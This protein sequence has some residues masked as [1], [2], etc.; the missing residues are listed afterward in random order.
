MASAHSRSSAGQGANDLHEALHVFIHDLRAPISVALGYLRLV[1]EDRLADEAARARA[2]EQTVE[3]LTRL[4]RLCDHASEFL[5]LAGGG[6]TPVGRSALSPLID[7]LRAGLAARGIEAEVEG[8][9]DDRAVIDTARP[10]DLADRLLVVVDWSMRQRC[11]GSAH[12]QT[13]EGWLRLRTGTPETRASLLS[14]EPAPIDW[15]RGGLGLL[16]AAACLDIKR[17]G[18]RVWT[19]GDAA[20]AVCV[21]LP[22]GQERA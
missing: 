17:H 22:V 16:L 5:S 13:V 21:T 20:P 12:I 4:S 18:G 3:S 11:G 8:L 9:V 14:G 1:R 15:R 7:R 2:L 10:D 6:S 19:T